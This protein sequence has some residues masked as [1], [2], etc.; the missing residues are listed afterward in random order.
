MQKYWFLF[1]FISLILC[2]CTTSNDRVV[3]VE[4][5]D[6]L[7]KKALKTTI[8]SS[9]IYLIQAE[10]L[11]KEVSDIP[12]SLKAENQYQIGRYQNEKGAI[13]SAVLYF[14]NATN[15]IKQGPLTQK[16]VAY[17]YSAW[18]AY[19]DKEE[20]GECIAINQKY[21]SLLIKNNDDRLTS[22]AHSLDKAIYLKTKEYK[23]ALQSSSEQIKYLKRTGDTS[24]VVSALISRTKILDDVDKD[25]TNVYQLLDSLVIHSDDY[26][27]GINRMLYGQY[28]VNL[29]KEK[30]YQ[31][32]YDYFNKGL[33][34]AKNI[35]NRG[36]RRK[37]ISNI[38]NNLTEVSLELGLY[39][40]AR[41]YLDTISKMGLSSLE[42]RQQRAYLRNQYKLSAV[43]NNDVT[44]VLSVLDSLN[45]YQNKT[46]QEKYTKDLEALNVSNENEK[47]LAT[48]KRDTEFKNFRLKTTLLI[49]AAVALLIGVLGFFYYR[50]KKYSLEREN[51]L[52][53]QRLLRAQMNPHFTFNT[54]TVIKDMI[55]KNPND[56]KNYLVKF[57]RLL[58]SIFEN[59]TFNYV[60]LEKEI[61]A[62]REY[63]DLQKIRFPNGFSYDIN[64]HDIEADLLYVPGMLL[65]PIIENSI[66]HG[67]LGI[68]YSGNIKISLEE[69]D[70]VILCKIEDNGKGMT[71]SPKV[72]T[73]KSST[74]LI[75][76]FIEKVTTSTF[77]VVNKKDIFEDQTGVI[78]TF[79]IPYKESIDD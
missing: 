56:A 73:R 6:L 5:I 3:L 40:E 57:S 36:T 51:L 29:F 65:Q 52:T 17:F 45:A 54:L 78:V 75:K 12:D 62:L 13:D 47:K 79:A 33:S 27:N 4:R 50:Q 76:T 24:D 19:L 70:T 63:M 66:N 26:S 18:D 41:A 64:L 71:P 39:K 21:K 28:G 74:T 20:Y 38:Y 23:K 61:D 68:E 22:I 34:Y 15:Y 11:M 14:Q 37:R 69:K 49:G 9:Y 42:L 55:D 72:S 43:T 8:D 32:A 77:T 30:R 2:S 44:Q 7:Q 25:L 35:E 60:L 53:Q 31:E 67:F 16:E 48:D 10:R 58:A 46:Y 1:F 59:S